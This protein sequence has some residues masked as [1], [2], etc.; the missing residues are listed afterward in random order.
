MKIIVKAKKF[1]SFVRVQKN[2]KRFTSPLL[3]DTFLG[4]CYYF[5]YSYRLSPDNPY[6]AAL[7]DCI[8]VVKF[9]TDHTEDFR[10]DP[11]RVAVGGDS[12]GGN[13]AAAI[14]LRM[15]D[16]IAMQFLIVPCLQFFDFKTTSFIENTYYFHDSINNPLSVVFVTN[17]LGI[18]PAHYKDFLNNNHTSRV[19]K[20]SVFAAMVNQSKWMKP[21]YVRNKNLLED[22]SNDLNFG[23]D[24]LSDSIENVLTDPFAAPLMAND[25]LL[26]DLP[27]AYIVTCGYDFVR[28]DGI[29]Y[30]ERLNFAGTKVIH[31]HYK[32]GFHH[33]WFFPH[34][35]LK[36]GVAVN[37]V[38][39]LVKALK[40]RL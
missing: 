39:D 20:R 37:I 17:Y 35:P 36:I 30:A 27:E 26:R 38:S 3:F 4:A 6:P 40:R 13:L 32:A 9:V 14:S 5:S 34:G 11:F 10:I 29:M 25:T 33:A 7:E 18:S 24:V 15:S 2:T 19:L 16:V 21:E 28:D 31:R 22:S 23:N 1:V 8:K 12:A